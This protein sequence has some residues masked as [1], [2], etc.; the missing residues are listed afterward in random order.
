[1]TRMVAL[2][3]AAM[4]ASAP[5]AAQDPLTIG[6]AMARARAGHPAARAAAAVEREADQRIAE[7]RAGYLP[8][9]DVSE[10][11]QRGNQPVFVF[12]TILSQRRFAAENF[13]IAALN[14]PDAV[15]NL[16]SAFTIEQP[17]YDAGLTRL[18]VQG[19]EIG[20]DAARAGR[21]RAEQDLALAAAQA[22]ARVVQLESTSR[23]ADSAVEAA[24]RDLERARDRRDAGLVT[25]AD[26]L[27][28]EVHL[29]LM[30]QHQVQTAGELRVARA[31][32]NEAIGAPLDAAFAVSLPPPAAA[33]AGVDA[34]EAE[35]LARR[36]E[37]REAALGTALAATARR[38]AQAAFLP[39][40]GVQAGYE[41][42]GEDFGSKVS[43][44]IVGAQVRLNVFRGFGD[45]ARLAG[46]REAETRQ[47]A[48]RDRV[49]RSVRLDVRAAVA[50]LEAA[51]AREAVGRAALSQ[52]RE[53]QRILR[54][55]YES[56]L[57]T[58]NDILRAAQAVLQAESQAIA[59]AVDVT[60]QS[61]ALERAV[62]RL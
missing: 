25:E 19:A 34:L 52:A 22:Y 38:T 42:N 2:L 16:R 7:A 21:A 26:V 20:R 47:A 11:W 30:R 1:M 6:D 13:A 9:A 58:V 31:Q 41:L 44:W 27:S 3:L 39:Q 28:V 53:S 43:G 14:H 49:E 37:V 45:R 29:A 15:S 59:A 18:A 33:A 12:G 36:P 5:A 40:V 23:A 8:R 46:A 50:R 55:R 35:A 4:A 56:G 61:L 51:A 48:E 24:A 62:G 10:S 60:L 57:A 17:V 54:D 32:L